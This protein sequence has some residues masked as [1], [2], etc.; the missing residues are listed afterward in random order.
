MTDVQQS[1]DPR[2]ADLVHAGTVRIALYPPQY[3]KDPVTGE[4]R[5]W[6]IELARALAARIGVELLPVEYPTPPRAMEGLK[7]GACDVG[8]GAMDPS[9]TSDVDF[10]PPVLQFEF[11]YLVPAGSAIRSIADADR[12]GIRIAVVRNHASTLC[13]NRVRK[14]AEMVSAETPDVAFD[15]LRTGQADA[16]ASTRPALLEFSSKLSGSLVLKDYFG[17]NFTAMTVPKGQDQ[18]LAYI[19]DFIE[20]AKASGLVQRVIT[21]SGWRGV[22]VAPPGNLIAQE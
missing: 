7:A 15:L 18:R 4:L 22:H 13:L 10:S 21:H 3:A 11:T 16:W 19:T 14:H 20:E 12:P 1:L 5:G 17:A 9:R 8:F 6:T 2:I